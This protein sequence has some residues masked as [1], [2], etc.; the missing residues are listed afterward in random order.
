MELA[1]H[2]LQML[3]VNVRVYLGGCD[4]TVSKHFLDCPEVCSALKQVRGERMSQRVRADGFRDTGLTAVIL[5]HL[6]EGHPRQR[7]ASPVQKE[8]VARLW[9]CNCAARRSNISADALYRLSSDGDKTFLVPFSG[10]ADEAFVEKQVAY[11]DGNELTYAETGRVRAF[12][13]S[14]VAKPKWSNRVR[15]VQKTLDLVSTENLGKISLEFWRIKGAGRVGFRHTFV[16][17]KPV[18]NAHGGHR[19][20]DT[21]RREVLAPQP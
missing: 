20:S 2:C 16:L 10:Y 1:V 18:K 14:T 19:S 12:Q 15:C 8:Y 11:V 3:P 17:Q 5:E 4:G 7:P 9:F 6:P 21:A 13:H